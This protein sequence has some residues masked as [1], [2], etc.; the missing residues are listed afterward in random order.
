MRTSFRER[1][2]YAYILLTPLLKRC[3]CFFW[4]NILPKMCLN[5]RFLANI[6]DTS[7]RNA[8][9]KTC[10]IKVFVLWFFLILLHLV[11]MLLRYTCLYRV[12][13]YCGINAIYFQIVDIC[14][15]KIN[16]SS[17]MKN[18]L[19]LKYEYKNVE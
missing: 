4:R 18:Y 12:K 3:T 5:T 13:R 7:C 17:C 1:F 14:H 15:F 9:Q 2:D 11:I 10:K 19:C 8:Q 6:S 16:F